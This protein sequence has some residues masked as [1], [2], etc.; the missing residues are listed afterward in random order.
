MN[1]LSDEVV[2]LKKEIEEMKMN[3]SRRFDELKK[4]TETEIDIPENQKENISDSTEDECFKCE[5]S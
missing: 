1:N 4:Y 3:L 5:I 2:K